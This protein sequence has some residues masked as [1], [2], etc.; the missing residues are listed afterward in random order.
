MK[1]LGCSKGIYFPKTGLYTGYLGLYRG[2]IK[3]V[4]KLYRG[5]IG[6]YR[7]YTWI[8]EKKM[9]TTIGFR[10]YL[11]LAGNEGMEKKMETTKM[12]HLGTTISIYSSIPS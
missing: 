6:F 7:G 3:V 4:W 9:E 11:W 8:T 1:P 5:Y 12:G 10:A 2:Y